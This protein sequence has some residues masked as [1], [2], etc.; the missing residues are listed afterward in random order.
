VQF[1][2]AESFSEGLAAVCVDGE[3]GYIDCTGEMIIKPRKIDSAGP[4]SGGLARVIVDYK[5][6]Y[7]DRAG[8]YVWRPTI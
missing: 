7:I 2:L 6:G 3:W 5:Y 4:F 8:T 1:E